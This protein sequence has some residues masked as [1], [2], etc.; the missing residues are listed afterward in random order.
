MEEHSFPSFRWLSDEDVASVVVYVRSI[1][2]VH[3]L[4]PK[5]RLTLMRKLYASYEPEPITSPVPPPDSSTAEKRGEY[6]VRVA[7]CVGCH[8]SHDD[9]KA[10]VYE[11]K[12]G[13]GN[14]FDNDPK[15]YLMSPNI[16]MDASGI[17]YYDAGLFVRT[18]RSGQVGARKLDPIMPWG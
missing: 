13:G 6:L 16:T 17:G 10:P 15:H 18:L 7:D 3:N 4:L 11:K 8:T 9:S 12:F 5:T 2:A 1:P 14:L